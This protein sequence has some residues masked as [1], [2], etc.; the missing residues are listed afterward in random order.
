MEIQLSLN[1]CTDWYRYLP[2]VNWVMLR[3]ARVV[4]T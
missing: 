2:I 1:A 3:R 4:N